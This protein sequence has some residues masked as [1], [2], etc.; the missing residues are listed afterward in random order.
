MLRS[1]F[2]PRLAKQALAHAQ[3]F[4]A[5]VNGRYSKVEIFP[6]LFGIAVVVV[7]PL[8]HSVAIVPARVV[9]WGTG[10]MRPRWAHFKIQRNNECWELAVTTDLSLLL[11]MRSTE[12]EI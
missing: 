3:L 6:M 2:D 8:N 1:C 11:S 9:N 10:V 12:L 7:H 5:D 4:L